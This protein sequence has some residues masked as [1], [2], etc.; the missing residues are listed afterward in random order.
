MYRYSYYRIIVFIVSNLPLHVFSCSTTIIAFLYTATEDRLFSM[1]SFCLDSHAGVRWQVHDSNVD[2][3]PNGVY[4]FDID[5]SCNNS[6]NR[7]C[8]T[9]KLILIMFMLSTMMTISSHNN[10][11]MVTSISV[12]VGYTIHACSC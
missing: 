8:N 10:L 2:K 7:V 5:F 3:Y 4:R 12:G 6:A 11:L 9:N 1:C